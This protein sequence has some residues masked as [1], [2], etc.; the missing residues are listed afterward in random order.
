MIFP[1]FLGI[2]INQ[3]FKENVILKPNWTLL[4]AFSYLIHFVSSLH[5]RKVQFI[6]PLTFESVSYILLSFLTTYLS[7]GLI[8]LIFNKSRWP[9]FV[10]I[11]LLFAVQF[12][13]YRY[14]LGTKHLFDPQVFLS[15][16]RLLFYKESAEV[17][18]SGLGIEF[19]RPM[20]ILLVIMFIVERKNK[21]I[22]R[23]EWFFSRIVS[24]GFSM[25]LF[26]GLFFG[27]KYSHD[28]FFQL[29]ISTFRTSEIYDPGHPIVKLHGDK[30][31]KL[32]QLQSQFSRDTPPNIFVVFIESFNPN[33][34]DKVDPET[35]VELMPFFN[36]LKKTGLYVENYWGNGIQTSRGLFN[37]FCSI[38]PS[39]TETSFG[40]HHDKDLNCLPQV[41]KDSGYQTHFFQAYR[42]TTFG[43]KLDFLSQNGFDHVESVADYMH[44]GDEEHIWGWGLQDDIYYKRFF[45]YLDGQ[46][47]NQPIFASLLTVSTHR[48]FTAIPNELKKVYPNYHGGNYYKRY[49]NV[50][51]RADH[52]L[53]TFLDEF[54]KRNFHKNSILIITG[55][56]GFPIDEH[57]SHH[58]EAGTFSENFKT[59]FLLIW[60]QKVKPKVI[61]D[62]NFS[63]LDLLPS[64]V[65]LAGISAK[66]HAAGQSLFRETKKDRPIFMVQPYQG[67][68]LA[69]VRGDFKY[70]KEYRYQRETLF[71][72]KNDP[73]ESK[74]L[75]NSKDHIFLLKQFRE[76]L[77]WFFLNHKLLNENKIFKKSG[78]L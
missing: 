58:N 6:L 12:A 27:K 64:L 4:L 24:L 5:G 48:D 36:E 77:G 39:F 70:V 33:F 35:G 10:A 51:N 30:E 28:P 9:K 23:G 69:V 47:S 71:D 62:R 11:F 66:T 54:K 17:V 41:L 57:G 78:A 7:V 34:V 21:L 32:K 19:Y 40:T 68:G 67:V 52:F 20:A 76:D 60:D 16:W 3:P 59:P 56:H 74:N 1:R 49:S 2:L 75:I 25:A 31:F 38:L 26:L 15:N 18:S 22:T 45:E 14:Q 55:D 44:P 72:L 43:S 63:H 42:D 73:M 13:L 37:A 65:D 8:F 53:R 46:D 50:I 61:R 29:L